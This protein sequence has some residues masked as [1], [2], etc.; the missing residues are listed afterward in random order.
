MVVLAD[1]WERERGWWNGKIECSGE[2]VP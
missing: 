2:M 1:R